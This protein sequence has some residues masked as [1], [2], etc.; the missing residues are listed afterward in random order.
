MTFN[1]QKKCT[2]NFKFF[3]LIDS[4]S[5]IS[6]I[7]LSRIPT[8]IVLPKDTVPTNFTGVGNFKIYIHAKINCTIEFRNKTCTLTLLVI[9]DEYINFPLILGRDFMLAFNICFMQINQESSFNYQHKKI[10]S[11]FH[12]KSEDN[13]GSNFEDK[14][15]CTKTFVSEFPLSN[16]KSLDK[17]N[18]VSD[19]FAKLCAIDLNLE[20][21]IECEISPLLSYEQY[22]IVQEV[23]FTSYV[24]PKDIERK[25]HNYE[26][27]IRLIDDIPI[28]CT[29]RRLSYRN[30]DL[31]K[32]ITEDLIDRKIIRPSA[33]P[34]ASV[35]VFTE[36]KNGD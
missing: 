9:P 3:S 17:L 29:P 22:N 13:I 27:K 26:M 28:H 15:L 7:Q 10:S 2:Q 16:L 8:S 12:L 23:I 11:A 33:S 25:P 30:R 24:D 31:I 20:K 19:F 21:D 1:L 14:N 4:G 35:I 6:L 18:N 34:Y 32:K 36:K 5:P